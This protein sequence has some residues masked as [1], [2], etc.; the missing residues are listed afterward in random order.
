MRKPYLGLAAAPS[1]SDP[2]PALAQA[3]T[4]VAGAISLAGQ[5]WGQSRRTN[6]LAAFPVQPPSDVQVQ[7]D[8]EVSLV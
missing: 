6:H 7:T 2:A 5:S 8:V 1:T 3:L 4:D